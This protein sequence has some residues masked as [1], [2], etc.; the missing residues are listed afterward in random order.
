MLHSVNKG[1][2]VPDHLVAELPDRSALRRTP[3]RLREALNEDGFALLRDALPAADVLAARA[4]VTTRLAGVGELHEPPTDAIVTGVSRRA[5]LVQDLGTFWKSVSEGT[6]LRNVTHGP[7]I[8]EIMTH[9]HGAPAIGHDLVYLRVAPP[10]QALDLHYD[11]PF[12]SRGTANLLTVWIPLGDV[13]VTDGPLFV[14]EGSNRY[15][16]LISEMIQAAGSA[17][18]ARKLSYE[19]PAYQFAAEHRTR[20]LTADFR[21]GDMVVFNMFTAHGSLDNCSTTG[22][23]RVSCD[24]RYQPADAPR[25]E[26]FF[27]P[28]PCGFDG[29]GYSNLNGS[30]PLTISWRTN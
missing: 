1:S 3:A 15:Q 19:Q 28:D 26:R 4:E 11:Y 30:K 25:D 29:A 6:K 16:D 20:L 13:P 2:R 23:A 9:I 27:G 14:V 22:R 5:E 18:T 8:T 10:G 21:V 17:S 12:F 24:V 7:A